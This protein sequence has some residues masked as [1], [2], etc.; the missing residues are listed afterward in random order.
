M[1]AS[2]VVLGAVPAVPASAF[3]PPGSQDLTPTEAV[4][5][6]AAYNELLGFDLT[7]AVSGGMAKGNAKAAPA[8]VVAEPEPE[9]EPEPES[10]AEAIKRAKA[11]AAAA[12]AKAKEEATSKAVSYTHLTLPTKRIV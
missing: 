2:A 5:Q 8:V 3:E 4:S 6:V 7:E 9:P 10:K 11:E 12:K 1:I